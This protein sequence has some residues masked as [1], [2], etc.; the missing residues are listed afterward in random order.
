MFQILDSSEI[1]EAVDLAC[2]LTGGTRRLPRHSSFQGDSRVAR[3]AAGRLSLL[4]RGGP[5]LSVDLVAAVREAAGGLFDGPEDEESSAMK[6]EKSAKIVD[7]TDDFFS[8]ASRAKPG[9]GGAWRSLSGL[10][11]ES[12]AQGE[13]EDDGAD[14]LQQELELICR[15][16]G[17]SGAVVTDDLGLPFA[18]VNPPVSTEDLSAF[19]SVLGQALDKAGAVIGHSG[20]EFLCLDIDYEQKVVLRRFAVGK[21]SCLLMVTCQQDVDERS[22]IEISIAR[23][24]ET[25]SAITE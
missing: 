18:A 1:A 9:A 7:I 11:S 6:R 19:C 15:R 12:A 17:F 5:K 16:S 20:A 14:R 13:S 22:E 3:R 21:E 8:G 10:R 2:G 24:S 4:P 23:L 25:L